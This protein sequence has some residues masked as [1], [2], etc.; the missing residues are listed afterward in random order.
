MLARMAT[1]KLILSNIVFK[2][3]RCELG[4]RYPERGLVSTTLW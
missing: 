1:I 2:A 3:L 4:K